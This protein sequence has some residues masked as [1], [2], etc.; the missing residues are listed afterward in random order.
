MGAANRLHAC[1]GKAEV[2]D[3]AFINQV[4]DCAGHIFD[5]HFGIYAVLIEEV[6]HIVFSRF[7]EASATS[8]MCSGRLFRPACLPFGVDVESELRCDDYLLTEGAR[9]HPRVPRL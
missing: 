8:L 4:L 5:R 9:L 6:D 7:S 1:L 3:L 2:P